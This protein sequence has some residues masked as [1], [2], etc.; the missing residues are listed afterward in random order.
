MLAIW[1]VNKDFLYIWNSVFKWA[2]NFSYVEPQYSQKR[3]CHTCENFAQFPT[4]VWQVRSNLAHICELFVQH[5][6]PGSR[7]GLV[8]HK[9][10]IK[11]DMLSYFKWNVHI[12]TV[13]IAGKLLSPL[14]KSEGVMFWRCPS[15]RP[16]FVFVLALENQ[17]K[18]L[19]QEEMKILLWLPGSTI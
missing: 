6:Y 3:I 10:K 9:I 15:V 18:L 19:Y 8:T 1:Q 7:N 4:L 13:N 2:I 5:I 12:F 17:R 16:S 14:L 11:G